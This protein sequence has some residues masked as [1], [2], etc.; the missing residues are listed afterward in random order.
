MGRYG[1]AVVNTVVRVGAAVWGAMG[2]VKGGVKETCEKGG[3][4]YRENDENKGDQGNE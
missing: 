1:V 3:E 4:G 2:L